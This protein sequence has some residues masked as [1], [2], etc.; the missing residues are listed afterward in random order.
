VRDGESR[1]I[2]FRHL[3]PSSHSSIPSLS[4]E[5]PYIAMSTNCVA[6]CLY[7]ITQ[8]SSTLVCILH[9]DLLASFNAEIDFPN[10]L[11][12]HNQGTVVPPKASTLV[13][14]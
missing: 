14:P 13:P 6:S 9:V 12:L 11:T 4:L 7:S 10:I 8:A 3:H 5:G 2:L 1:Q